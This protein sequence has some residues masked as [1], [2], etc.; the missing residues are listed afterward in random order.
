VL[1]WLHANAWVKPLFMRVPTKLLLRKP[2]R[3]GVLVLSPDG[4]RPLYT[5]MYEGPLL[6]SI[7]SAVPSPRGVYLANLVLGNR[8]QQQTGLVR[9]DWPSQ[10]R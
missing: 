7:A 10:L 6:T 4:R 2:R 8:E 3:T 9:L 5:A 1:T